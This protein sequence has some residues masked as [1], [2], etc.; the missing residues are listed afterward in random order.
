MSSVKYTDAVANAF[1]EAK[2]WRAASVLLGLVVGI[3]AIALVM[4]SRA[5][6]LTLVP[7]DFATSKGGPI[8]IQ[9]TKDYSESSPD[10]LAQIALGD[11]ALVLNWT[12]ENVEVQ[13]QRFL[14]RMTTELYAEQNVSMLTQAAE[15]K[16]SSTTQSFYPS[17]TRV[18]TKGS[19]VIV[20]G[21]LVRWTGEKESIRAKVIYTISYAKFR[22]YAH[23]ASLKIQK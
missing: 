14:N 15:F 20:E 18:G 21:T 7:M 10:Y 17:T 12:P 8:T 4:Q 11:L 16:S 1:S 3:L 6:P 2:A 22:G 19:Q 9:P 13:H 23:V 5:T